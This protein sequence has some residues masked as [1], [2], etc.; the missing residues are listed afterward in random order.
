M[1]MNHLP[2]VLSFRRPATAL[3]VP[4]LAFLLILAGC[5]KPEVGTIAVSPEEA[6]VTVGGETRFQAEAQSTKDKPMDSVTFAWSVDGDAGS[7]GPD[8]TFVAERPGRATVVAEGESVQGEASVTVQPVPVASL[9]AT[10][11]EGPLLAGSEI[12]VELASLDSDG[13]PA[14]YHS[15]ALSSE[16]AGLGLP[17]SPI[18]L[19][20]NGTAS[21]SLRLPSQ[22]GKYTVDLQSGEIQ[23]EVTL[24]VVPLPIESLT[25]TPEKTSDLVGSTVA[26]TLQA[27]ATGGDAA[28]Y[29][30]IQL[31]SP[32]DG[33]S[34]STDAVTLDGSGEASFTLDLADQPGENTVRAAGGGTESSATVQGNPPVQ[35]S[36]EPRQTEFILGAS[37]PL[38]ARV[39]DADGNSRQVAPEWSV[40]GSVG[41]IDD[42]TLQ[43]DQVG[44]GV[45]IARFDS[46]QA[47]LSFRVV[48]GAPASVNV[49]PDQASL[50]AGDK[51]A[52]TA[53]VLNPEGRVLA[54][55]VEWSAEGD[56]G[57]IQADG[58]FQATGAGEGSV[59]A[60]AGDATGSV[61][62][63]VAPGDLTAIRIQL[64]DSTF[65][66]GDEVPLEA[67]GLDAYGNSFP[68]TPEWTVSAALG[69]IDRD[70]ARFLPRTVGAGFLLASVDSVAA[71]QEIEVV[72]GTPAE[73]ELAPASAN[74]VAGE[75]LPF[76]TIV[77]DAFGNPIEA[78]ASLSLGTDLGTLA[79]DG[80]FS[81]RKAG[82][83][84]LQASFDDLS[85]ESNL[86]VIPARMERVE[87][88]P[89]ATI[90][91]TAGDAVPLRLLGFD[92]FGNPVRA[93]VSWTLEPALGPIDPDQV[94]LPEKAGVAS[95]TGNIV[96]DRTGQTFL[97]TAEVSVVPGAT[98][99]LSVHP[100]EVTTTAGETVDFEATGTDAFGNETGSAVDWSLQPAGVGT[101]DEAGRLQP[102]RAVGEAEVTARVGNVVGTAALEVDPAEPSF[103]RISPGSLEIT[104]GQT[105]TVESIVEDRF[106]NRID[107]PVRWSLANSAVGEMTGNEFHPRTAGE[108]HLRATLG[109]LA[110]EI[111]V[112][113]ETGPAT[114]V[115][116]TTEA[117]ELAAGTSLPLR[118]EVTDAGGNPVSSEVS[119]SL[120]GNGEGSGAIGD[121]DTFT[122]TTAGPVTL[123]ATLPDGA[124]DRHALTI[125]PGAPATVSVEPASIEVVAGK[126]EQ[127]SVSV[128]DGEG[129]TL[130]DFAPVWS[131]PDDLGSI[132]EDEVFHAR[133]AGTGSLEVT[134]GEASTSVE[135][136]VVPGPV[137]S[138]Q[139]EPAEATLAAGE[140]LAL[141]AQPFDAEGNPLDMDVSFSATGGIGNIDADGTFAARTVGQGNLVA[142][143][144]PVA[145]VTATT[146]VPGPIDS[147]EVVPGDATVVA[148]EIISLAATARDAFGNRVPRDLF[149]WQLGQGESSP[150][151]EAE[152]V[153]FSD[154]E[155]GTIAVTAR[156]NGVAGSARVEVV[157]AALDR[158]TVTPGSISA[159]SGDS[160]PL[161]IEGLDRFGN[162]VEIK[163]SVTTEPEELGTHDPQAG[164]WT[165]AAE[166]EGFLRIQQGSTESMIPLA[167]TPGTPVR[168][169]IQGLEE[170]YVAGR[171]YPHE[172]V[173]FDA[174]GNRVSVEAR[175]AVSPSI[176]SVEAET[177]RLLAR[178]QGGG[179]LVGLTDG[180][181]VAESIEVRP[182]EVH[183]YF[184]EPSPV[185]LTA[186]A[187]Q[188]ITVEAF[189]AQQNPVP[190][191]ADA[192][193]WSIV[194]PIAEVVRP[195]VVRGTRE[196]TG[197]AIARM[198][199]LYGEAIL[200][201][202]PGA[203]DL[204]QSR[205]RTVHAT[206]P[207][208]GES[209]A[210]L[211]IEVR[212]AYRNPV[213]GVSV[214]LVSSRAEDTISQIPPTDAEGETVAQVRSS[215]PGESIYR[216]LIDGEVSEDSAEVQFE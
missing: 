116:I 115:R 97:R 101:I 126:T 47:N 59:V 167:V 135:A 76:T 130:S 143:A 82:N 173:G 63:T 60:T 192:L 195:G 197:K 15:V 172:L 122:A 156:A 188:V 201:V 109:S 114:N 169:E 112:T 111:P 139:V 44:E 142:R 64:E 35:I 136:T 124:S 90:E 12:S 100:P 3:A 96:Q 57:T 212:D 29:N 154:R 152:E 123:L 79:E 83:G 78:T 22:P 190:L 67:V 216:L 62:V 99:Q 48:P 93:T 119:W 103:L 151:V 74:V 131:I 52:F 81:A 10:L 54:E 110:A 26:V 33:T 180:L 28:G 189:D 209:E 37:V 18:D 69:P 7:I 140:T 170:S 179:V 84:V 207:A 56:I 117:D 160:V 187:E 4:A 31:S 138:V 68:I 42:D 193:E 85:A 20:A 210:D 5:G 133:M 137:A 16:A 120:E 213:P 88:Q 206:V 50:R 205:L 186:G 19:G 161:A 132:G 164:H 174:G 158:F 77:R 211:L 70:P 159:A 95:L 157:P 91:A 41:S 65:A 102:R 182:G 128:E 38:S 92:S 146:V 72:P 163:P 86:T 51:T 199:D 191:T 75:T 49:T 150:T 145:E 134:V 21:A 149:Q 61:P 30:R 53:Q 141:Q 45:L 40:G 87:I 194:G 181:T 127:F 8:G 46:L 108:S 36:V 165:A 55:P 125:V 66:A 32:T 183:T 71:R 113:V 89:S 202:E 204:A 215:V 17:S 14:G 184:L 177:G 104:A 9:Q 1:A 214:T 6:A 24:E 58:T 171:D 73:L 94:F 39:A 43:L 107:Q 147:V 185:T 166:G 80:V 23:Q 200:R 2:R 176:G 162:T 27:T 129:N 168:L 153:E 208:N 106:G 196:G 203:P 148:G 98:T 178:T 121:D 198:G 118:A 105:A 175:W 144:G 34:L 25:V 155:V 13:S 11:P